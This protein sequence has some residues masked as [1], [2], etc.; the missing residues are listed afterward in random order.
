MICSLLSGMAVLGSIYVLHI[1]HTS[2]DL[3]P[4][5][6]MLSRVRWLEKIVFWSHKRSNRKTPVIERNDNISNMTIITQDIE[7]ISRSMSEGVSDC[8]NKNTSRFADSYNMMEIDDGKNHKNLKQE[9]NTMLIK[10]QAKNRNGYQN[11]TSSSSS[12]SSNSSSNSSSSNSSISYNNLTNISQSTNIRNHRNRAMSSNTDSSNDIRSL[13]ERTVALDQLNWKYCA[14]V[15][16]RFFFWLFLAAN[17][18]VSAV[19][20]AVYPSVRKS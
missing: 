2:N 12:S 8:F 15:L 1:Y 9:N 17:F 18:I 16:D 14:E 5:A 10:N 11:A 20:L 4:T 3:Q 19:L 13:E 6:T 7:Y